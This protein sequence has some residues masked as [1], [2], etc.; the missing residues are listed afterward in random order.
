VSFLVASVSG[1]IAELVFSRSGVIERRRW[2]PSLV[3]VIALFCAALLYGKLRAT[4][5]QLVAGPRVAIVQPNEKHYHNDA[6]NR[7]LFPHQLDFTRKE[8]P[9]GATDLI[10]W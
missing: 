3:I 1:L 2:I 5:R 10:G 4:D 9:A 7:D 6:L 8:I